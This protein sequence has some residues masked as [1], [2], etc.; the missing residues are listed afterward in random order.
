MGHEQNGSMK[1]TQTWWPCLLYN[2]CAMTRMQSTAIIIPANTPPLDRNF[3]M[4]PSHNIK[5]ACW[6]ANWSVGHPHSS[7]GM[8]FTLPIHIVL[9]EMDQNNLQ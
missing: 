8:D 2:C 3:K 1:V 7:E 4:L 9:V 6:Q 5:V